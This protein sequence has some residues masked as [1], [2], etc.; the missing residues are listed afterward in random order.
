[1]RDE[2]GVVVEKRKDILE[3]LDHLWEGV[4]KV[5]HSG[6]DVSIDSLES[7]DKEVDWMMEPVGFQEM[8]IL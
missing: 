3:V 1:M 4:R 2:D 5:S 7:K 8:F 6:E